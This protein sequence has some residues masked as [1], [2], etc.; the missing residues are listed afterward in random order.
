MPF[1]LGT[2]VTPERWVFRELEGNSTMIQSDDLSLKMPC[3]WRSEQVV[4]KMRERER[5]GVETQ[6][7]NQ[8]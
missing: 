4:K 2:S 5:E 7:E 1:S 6:M 3:A 8:V